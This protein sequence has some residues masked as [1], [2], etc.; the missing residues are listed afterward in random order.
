MFFIQDGE[1]I[2]GE[3]EMFWIDDQEIPY[4]QHSRIIMEGMVED[5]YVKIAY[6]QFGE[7]R[8]TSG[9]MKLRITSDNEMTG[10]FEGTAANSKG[11][12]NAKV[13]N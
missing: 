13:L 8:T 11:V 9:S 12:V 4:T 10:T 1:K 7:R 6:T 3:G 5:E 2:K